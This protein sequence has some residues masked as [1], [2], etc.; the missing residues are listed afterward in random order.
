MRYELEHIY[1]EQIA[2]LMTQIIAI[3]QEHGIPMIASFAYRCD[4]QGE[5]DL[6]T[7]CLPGPD[8]NAPPSYIDAIDIIYKAGSEIDPPLT[9]SL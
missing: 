8:N 2:P 4:A 3:C 9:A 5:Y 7:S 6:C 1:D